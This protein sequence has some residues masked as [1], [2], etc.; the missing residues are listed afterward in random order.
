M[1]KRDLHEQYDFF[2]YTRVG[3]SDPPAARDRI[4]VAVLDM[5][6]ASSNLRHDQI[7]PAILDAAELSRP[8]VVAA[9]VKVRALSYDVRRTGLLPADP[10][11]RFGLY[12]ATGG[13]GHLD[14][15]QND[16]VSWWAQGV[17][18]ETSWEAPLFHLFDS[19]VSHPKAGLISIC[20][21]FGLMC[22]WSG[23]AK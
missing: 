2:E 20:H 16:G 1:K 14:P 11:G 18:E 10:D 13:P 8:S 15:R 9:G 22:R 3:N 7:I 21:S 17:R 4:D 19:I 5:N 23:V 12:V 6:H